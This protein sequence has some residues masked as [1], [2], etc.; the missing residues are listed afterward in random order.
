[1]PRRLAVLL[2]F[3]VLTPLPALR[4]QDAGVEFFEKKIRPL[5]VDH[6]YDCHAVGAKKIRGGL[7]LDSR[8]AVRKGGDSGPAVE[9][10]DPDKSL[11]VKAVRFTDDGL[12][13][14]PKGK[15]SATA[16]ADLEAW[17][18][19]GAPDP[20]DKAPVRKVVSSWQDVVA[21][22]RKWWSLQPVASPAVPQ[23]KNQAWSTQPIDR[24]LLAKLEEKNL[25]PATPA[26]PRT[27]IRR[28]SIVLT[29]LPP[30]SE[31]VEAFVREMG[32]Q[33]ADAPRSPAIVKLV[34]TLLASPHFGERW[35]RHW[36][37][38][39]RY[40]ETHGNEWN[41]EV[42]HAWRYRDYLIRA[43]NEDVPYD[44]LV[45]EHLAGDLLPAPRWNRT[46]RFNESVIGTAFY[47]FGE[48]NHDDCIDLRQIGYDLADNQIDTLTK[49]FQ[50]TTV[51]CA[52][53]HDHKIDA[54]SMRD[55]YSLL[56]V[57]RSSR[58]VSHSLDGLEVNAGTLQKMRTIKPTIRRELA[59]AWLHA[60]PQAKDL[61]AAAKKDMAGLEHPLSPLRLVLEAQDKGK[62]SFADA[63]KKVADQMSR[64]DAERTKH[65]EAYTTLADFRQGTYP[66]WSVGGQGLRTPPTPSGEF[67]V[68][69]DGE[70]A[71]ASILPAGC[72]THAL[73]D[74]L[75]GTLR[76]P[77]LATGKKNISFRVMGQ[78]A[79]A[80][81]LVS[82]NCQLNYRNYKALVSDDLQWV[83]FN[84]P[85]AGLNLR[86]Y[87]ELMT[88]FDNPK[89]PDQLGTLGGDKVNDRVP[90]EVAAKNPRSHFGVTQVVVH[91]Q[92]G[93]PKPE[94]TH[95][96]SLF[97]TAPANLD[98]LAA[99]YAQ[100][101]KLALEA[102]RDDKATDDDVRWLDAFLQRG[103]LSNR[104]KL[105]PGLDKAIADY[106]RLDGELSLPR[107]SP[108][109]ADA[110]PGFDQ[111]LFVRGDC[112][113]P[114]ESVP[115][116]Y[117]A[118]LSSQ[119]FPEGGS[120]RLELAQAIASPS[121]P[122]TARVMANRIW[123]HLFG[124]GLVRTVDDFGHVGELPSH[125]ELLDYLASRFV[126]QGWSTK[127]LIRDIVL[128]RAFQASHEPSPA[129][130]EVDPNNRLLQHYPARRMEAEAIRDSLLAT[131]G[132]LDRTLFGMSV[133]AFRD[134]DNEYRRLFK[135][136]LDGHGRRSV[137][138]KMTLMEAPKFLEAFNLPG[139]K[140]AQGR[141]DVTNVPA[142][143]LAMLNDPFVLQQADVW[144]KELVRRTK[145]DL[146]GRI[147]AM[148]RTALGRPARA[149][150]LERFGRFVNEVATLHKVP[151]S[152]VLASAVV[153]RDMSHVMFNLQEFISIP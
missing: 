65:N 38:V 105:T 143:A 14:P 106:R 43:F 73:S 128:T 1:M 26:D 5:L 79:S 89:F 70:Q 80:V 67:V 86:V 116:R 16:I 83:S 85:D 96:R 72:F 18:K 113:K 9:P 153:W 92:G 4:G 98:E 91:D 124:A 63:W 137:Y 40:T 135:G 45:R 77:T 2:C 12:K 120:G 121:N 75:N 129:C 29:G 146:N 133:P 62:L 66:T 52:R 152:D 57:I 151:A 54:V 138:I 111:P 20:R 140:V 147:D 132:R 17:V 50:A 23:P 134:S 104:A 19:M 37:D 87:G 139:G 136:P 53:C 15:L 90:W 107:V 46:D 103:L 69:P 41:Y 93:P 59:D 74:K 114:S 34:D 84:L 88:M 28:L 126:E 142:Q 127:R 60:L 101:V 3:A 99:R 122:L 95:L 8:D 39:V 145:D 32:H 42:H 44:Q 125:P 6:C 78:H 68:A 11:I 115:R 51:S 110:G 22:R 25:T 149:E 7:L 109:L 94:L 112:Y 118:V 123:H 108:G 48:V 31:Q 13:M 141:R 56:G 117:V 58:C 33:G 47:R 27:L 100:R 81:R 64:E 144:G 35:A 148:F 71:V 30:T 150:E 131:S 49:A 97:A 55:Y 61:L 76:S 130:L 119:V 82:N 36:M 102:W 21:Q 10:G 24:F